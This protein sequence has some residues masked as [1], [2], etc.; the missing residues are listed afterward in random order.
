LSAGTYRL[1]YTVRD[2]SN[3]DDDFRIYVDNIYARTLGGGAGTTNAI[4]NVIADANNYRA[5]GDAWGAHDITGTEGALVSMIGATPWSANSTHAT[6]STAAGYMAVTGTY[7][8]LYIQAD[9]DYVYVPNA[10]SE[11][12][13]KQDVFSYTLAQT[14]GDSDTAQLVIGIATS[15]YVAPEPITVTENADTALAGTA[16]GDVILGLAGSDTLDGGDGNDHLEGGAGVDQLLGGAGNDM[17]IGGTGADVFRW[18]LGEQ[19]SAG[20][21]AIDHITDFS[22]VDGDTLN[23]ADLL[24]DHGSD[25]AHYLKFGEVGTNAVLN[26]SRTGDVD[27]PDQQIVFDNRTLAQLEGDFSAANA[28]ELLTKMIDS[29]LLKTDM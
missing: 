12:V 11:N 1:V 23:L 13:G 19:G 16:G 21:P 14:D 25:L 9:G 7:G 18:S 26:I 17:L 24:Q 22:K 3:N 6:Y 28:A 10:N 15:A 5:S 29:H 4:G 27:H 8:K 20:A 2:E